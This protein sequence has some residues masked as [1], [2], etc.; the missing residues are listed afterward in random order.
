MFD[1]WVVFVRIDLVI[2]PCLSVCLGFV[3]VCG[4]LIDRCIVGLFVVS[5]VGLVLIRCLGIVGCM[6]VGLFDW[7][8]CCVLSFSFG[9]YVGSVGLRL[10]CVLLVVCFVRL[11]VG[12]CG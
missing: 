7:V 8:V 6:F 12:V 2:F 9:G 10:C 3:I 4:C 11:C 1:C 5:H